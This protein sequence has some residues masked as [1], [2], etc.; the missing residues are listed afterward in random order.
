MLR[1]L[2]NTVLAKM[3]QG[4]WGFQATEI[5]HSSA[6]QGVQRAV[7]SGSPGPCLR[8]GLRKG[9]KGLEDSQVSP[10]RLGRCSAGLSQDG[11]LGGSKSLLR[12]CVKLAATE[13]T[14]SSSQL[15]LGT[16]PVQRKNWDDAKAEGFF[17]LPLSFLP[18][19]QVNLAIRGLYP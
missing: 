12:T 14:D 17:F 13:T 10:G 5:I 1:K 9:Q 4:L 11:L 16:I 2:A 19:Q 6:A 18:S 7:F 8:A 3:S 15:T